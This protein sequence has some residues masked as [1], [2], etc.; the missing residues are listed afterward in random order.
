MPGSA[1]INDV[2]SGHGCWPS[3]ITDQGSPDTFVNSRNVHRQYDHWVT[4]CCP[5]NGCHDSYLSLGSP[6]SF[7]NG[8]G[9]GR[10]ADDIACGS[11]VATGSS[12][13]DVGPEPLTPPGPIDQVYFKYF[14][15]GLSR[16]GDKLL[17]IT[18]VSN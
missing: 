6:I 1:R 15:A 9:R 14:R 16:A 11:I 4:H 13:C 17:T 5:N 12:D 10:I 8:K 3:R 2:G 18:K 7:V